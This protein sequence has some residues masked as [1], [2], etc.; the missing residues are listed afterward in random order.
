M[1]RNQ[2]P[3]LEL[4]RVDPSRDDA[5]DLVVAGGGPA[6]LAVASR[7]AAAGFRVAVLDPNPVCPWVNNYGVWC[8]E[9]E[10]MGLQDCF[11]VVWP[12]AVVYLD[13]T[14]DGKK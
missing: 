4:P 8:D 10:A 9:F 12:K 1:A 13:A 5:Y 3:D 14:P 6:G 2:L 11:D 7:V